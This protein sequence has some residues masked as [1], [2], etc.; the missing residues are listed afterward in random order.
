MGAGERS[1]CDAYGKER[2]LAAI[3][4][5]NV[6]AVSAH[7]NQMVDGLH[8]ARQR[9]VGRQWCFLPADKEIPAPL[10][11]IRSCGRA[12]YHQV[13]AE[14]RPHMK[15][16]DSFVQQ[17]IRQRGCGYRLSAAWCNGRVIGAQLLSTA[18]DYARKQ[19]RRERELNRCGEAASAR[20]NI[21]EMGP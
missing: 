4:L 14:L 16:V 13:M 7:G 5:N 18:R 17:V 8:R 15:D 19:G 9:F 11:R 1:S 12:S 10:A 2:T 3:S 20:G 6:G 21:S